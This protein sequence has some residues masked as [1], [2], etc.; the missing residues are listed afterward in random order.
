[1]N[2][3]FKRTAFISKFGDNGKIFAVTFFKQFN[4]SLLKISISFKKK[5]KISY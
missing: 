1:M 3:G 4:A 5:K 2:S